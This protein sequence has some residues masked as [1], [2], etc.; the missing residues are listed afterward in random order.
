MTIEKML[1]SQQLKDSYQ[2]CLTSYFNALIGYDWKSPRACFNFISLLYLQS[3]FWPKGLRRVFYIEHFNQTFRQRYSIFF[4]G[5]RPKTKSLSINLFD[6][7]WFQVTLRSVTGC[8]F[9]WV[10]QS[11]PFPGSALESASTRISSPVR[12]RARARPS[13]TSHRHKSHPARARR[14]TRSTSGNRPVG[15]WPSLRPKKSERLRPLQAGLRLPTA[16]RRRRPRRWSRKR[17]K[18]S[19]SS[20][21]RNR[22]VVLRSFVFEALSVYLRVIRLL[23][24]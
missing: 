9:L 22:W 8:L 16:S 10:H 12:A 7:D 5:F 2:F 4:S 19:C 21:K 14:W 23:Y 17:W 24:F 1:N 15:G 3:Q 20:W 6:N 18:F 11:R 13:F